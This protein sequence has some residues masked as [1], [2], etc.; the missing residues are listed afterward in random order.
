ME[1]PGGSDDP[2][3]Y[4]SIYAID[5]NGEITGAADKVHLVPFGEYVP[6]ES[7]LRRFGVSEV[8]EMPGGFTAGNDARS[9]TVMDNFNMPCP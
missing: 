6:L 9:L 5:G 4:N 7:I 2:L 8:V 1:E 3:Y